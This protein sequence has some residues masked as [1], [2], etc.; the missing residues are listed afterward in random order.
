MH[1]DRQGKAAIASG[2]PY[3]LKRNRY[4]LYRQNST[5]IITAVARTKQHEKEEED[6]VIRSAGG[7]IKGANKKKEKKK[8]KRT[9]G[10]S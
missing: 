3:A 10:K 7:E 6:T 2:T 4:L 5:K 9:A 1:G 8:Q